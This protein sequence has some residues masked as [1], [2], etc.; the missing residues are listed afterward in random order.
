LRDRALFV[1]FEFFDVEIRDVSGAL[2]LECGGRYPHLTIA[3][4][5]GSGGSMEEFIRYY[6][7][8]TFGNK[9]KKLFKLLEMPAAAKVSRSIELL[10]KCG[11]MIRMPYSRCIATNLFELRITGKQEIRLFYT[12]KEG[13]IFIIH[14][15]IKK[16]NQIPPREFK[17]ALQKKRELE[18]L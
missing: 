12:F 4:K 15:F 14:G 1:G 10:K 3:Q 7:V 13:V 11:P 5:S 6:S 8:K 2:I 9:V 18:G 17:T 16:T